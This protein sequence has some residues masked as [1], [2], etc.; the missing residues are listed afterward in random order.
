M[1]DLHRPLCIAIHSDPKQAVR[2]I[3]DREMTVELRD[4]L[5]GCSS[6]IFNCRC[7]RLIE[8]V[9]WQNGTKSLKE[10]LCLIMKQLISVLFLNIGCVRNSILIEEMFNVLRI[11]V[12]KLY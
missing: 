6:L 1:K 11:E 12:V 9:V 5:L 2:I 10:N 4:D 7:S 3:F 8:V